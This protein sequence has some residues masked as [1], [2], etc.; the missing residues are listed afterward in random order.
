[1]MLGL[2][3]ATAAPAAPAEARQSS[4][5]GNGTQSSSASAAKAHRRDREE[6]EEMEVDPTDC[7]DLNSLIMQIAQLTLYNSRDIRT[8][9]SALK[10]VCLFSRGVEHG[11]VVV[12]A[13]KSTT[14]SYEQHVKSLS[15]PDRSA[16]APPF[17]FVW[18]V[19]LDKAKDI[20]A[21]EQLDTK[22]TKIENYLGKIGK[23]AQ[24]YMAKTGEKNTDTAKQK[25]TSV[26]LQS[27]HVLK[28]WNPTMARLEVLTSDQETKEIAAVIADVLALKA[29]GER[30]F[31]PQPKGDL[32]RRILKKVQKVRGGGE[33]PSR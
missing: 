25:V 12:E 33:K 16:F 8:V 31:G 22:K 28:C 7:N 14:R 5:R 27:A 17:V 3:V 32:E 13:V 15:T 19:L 9:S 10:V 26:L 21:A 24:E 4:K 29:K 23:L 18:H 11:K 2:P 1:M 20:C 6:V 30:K